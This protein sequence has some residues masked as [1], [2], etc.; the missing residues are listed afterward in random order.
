MNDISAFAVYRLPEMREPH[1]LIQ[2]KGK[3]ETID[4]L[5]NT[6]KGRGFMMAPF[7]E[8]TEK[9]TVFIKAD[10]EYHGDKKVL[11]ALEELN[12]LN[13]LKDCQ[14]KQAIDYHETYSTFIHALKNDLFKKLVLS[15][16]EIGALPD[17]FSI[18]DVFHKACKCYPRMMVYM[19]YTPQ[20][21]L[22]MGCS[23]EIIISGKQKYWH[24]VALAGTQP[25]KNGR[26]PET[27][28]DKDRKEQRYV[29]EYIEENLRQLAVDIREEGPYSQRAGQLAHL[30]SD[31]S[32]VLNDRK[33]VMKLLT[34]LHPTPAVCGLPKLKA[35]N[36]INQ[37]EGYD[38]RYYAGIVGPVSD[39]ETHL[40]VNLRCAELFKDKMVLYAGGGLLKES[41]ELSE[42]K[43][44][45]EKMKTIKDLF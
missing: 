37:M 3:I 21:G 18:S 29:S 4:L 32:F 38:R 31:F 26:L 22:W 7:H 36:F 14:Y 44:I 24:T 13:L 11:T 28:S 42:A 12:I 6:E 33:D 34:T 20:T 40:F 45:I 10:K 5:S 17:H 41:D 39:D 27:W 15:R 23:P 9:P 25:L 30:K 8:E 35:Y 16:N 2:E 1:L 43:E 19:C